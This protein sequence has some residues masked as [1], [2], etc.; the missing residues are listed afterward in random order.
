[1]PK[2]HEKPEFAVIGFRILVTAVEI[3]VGLCISEEFRAYSIGV[4]QV[5]LEESGLC[6]C[7]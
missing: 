1:M 4:L 3:N 7:R 6:T 5:A 2:S